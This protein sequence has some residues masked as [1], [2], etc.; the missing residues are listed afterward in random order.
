MDRLIHKYTIGYYDGYMCRQKLTQGVCLA[1][2]LMRFY[3]YCTFGGAT[4]SQSAR[5]LAAPASRTDGKSTKEYLAI[6]KEG[7]QYTVATT[8]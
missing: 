7:A 8:E 6:E 5:T 2:M 4:N 1:Q 3:S